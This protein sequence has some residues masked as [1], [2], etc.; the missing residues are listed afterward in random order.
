MGVVNY[1]GTDGEILGDSASGDY[2]RDALGSVTGTTSPTN[3]TMQNTYRYKPY[4]SE[5]SSSG[6]SPTPKYQWV[7]T[8]GYRQT[9]ISRSASYVRAR[10]YG[11]E[12]G[13]WTTVDPL[14][15]FSGTYS[16]AKAT[17]TVRTD[18]TG[19]LPV[20]LS[21]SGCGTQ[22]NKLLNCCKGLAEKFG[23]DGK[24]SDAVLASIIDCMR[25]KRFEGPTINAFIK[26]AL[27]N[28]VDMCSVPG[29]KST[30][31]CI[32]C[33]WGT[34]LPMGCDP[35]NPK[36]KPGQ[37]PKGKPGAVTVVPRDLPVIPIN[38]T[39]CTSEFQ[40]SD[41]PCWPLRKQGICEC[42]IVFCVPTWGSPASDCEALFHEMTHCG[43]AGS[44]PGHNDVG[45]RRD[46]IYALSCC[47]CQALNGTDANCSNCM[48]WN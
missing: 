3:A 12:E 47:V 14:W 46:I 40:D 32:Y 41:S 22:M 25:K 33:N 37:P 24:V 13:K 26:A 45:V 48:G 17:P 36:S 7:G 11:Q 2:M 1:Y 27:Q 5:L 15:P 30:N 34:T 44:P 20:I 16:Y 43:G 35:C 9:S 19:L 10:R 28:M 29:T 31:V 6:G 42:A 38:D 8:Y 21:D 23:K 18:P 39:G 4:G